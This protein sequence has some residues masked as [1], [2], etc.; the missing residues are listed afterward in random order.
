[1]NQNGKSKSKNQNNDIVYLLSEINKQLIQANELKSLELR[2]IY[3]LK[4]GKDLVIKN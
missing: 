4:T 1:M 2:L 3:K